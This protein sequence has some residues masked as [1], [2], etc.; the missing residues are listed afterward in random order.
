MEVTL[1]NTL[2]P[3]L[4]PAL[5]RMY[6]TSSPTLTSLAPGSDGVGQLYA[7]VF[8][9]LGCAVFAPF[10]L[11]QL[12]QYFFPSQSNWAMNKVYLFM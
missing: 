4:S 9:Q 8:K 5:A 3:F 12:V 6:I 10:A 11:G 2:G 7:A 1:G